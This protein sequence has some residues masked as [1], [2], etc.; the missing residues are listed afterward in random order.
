MLFISSEIEEVARNCHRV[1]VLRE[2]VV[3]EEFTAEQIDLPRLL[4]AM[5]GAPSD[6]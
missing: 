4:R 6:A 1:Y 2:R 3:H 5:A